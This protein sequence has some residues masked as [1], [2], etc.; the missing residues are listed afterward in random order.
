MKR[1]LF[2]LL[3]VI[4]PAAIL[5]ILIHPR[6]PAAERGR[7]LAEETGCFACHG[8]GGT[9]GT[10]NPGRSDGS[11][12]NWKGDVMMFADGPDEIREWIHDG[13]TAKRAQSETF[14]RE[15]EAG[16]LKMPAF[17]KRLGRRQIDD[18]VAYVMAVSG[19]DRPA[20]GSDAAR[21]LERVRAL[22][23][24]GC[25]G[26]GGRL[27]RPNPGSLKGYVP[28]WSGGDFTELVRDRDEFGEWVNDGVSKRF[29]GN[30]FAR[31]FLDRAVLHMPAYREHLEPGDL[32]A[33]WAYVEWLRGAS[34]EPAQR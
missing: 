27:A 6:I 16:V 7:R 29:Q 3:L 15:R 19:T 33:M 10:S 2:G 17:G 18:L 31:F 23:C 8:D 13:V 20:D 30:P 34:D 26:A 11:V 14:R 21:G 24:N 32:D 5:F 4:A 1:A 12:P 22:G 28:A 25:H 9:H